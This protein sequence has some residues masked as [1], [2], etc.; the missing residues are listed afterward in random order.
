[1][2][3]Y[4]GDIISTGCP[5]GARIKSGDTVRARIAGV[6]TLGATVR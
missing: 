2:T 4:P 1:M 5:K 6:G 3:L